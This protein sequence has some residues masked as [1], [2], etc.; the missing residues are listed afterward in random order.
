MEVSVTDYSKLLS[1]F[2]TAQGQ[3]L[4][5]RERLRIM[6]GLHNVELVIVDA[7]LIQLD[8]LTR[9]LS[10]LDDIQKANGKP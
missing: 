1:D 8:H 4:M 9:H 5:E 3:L 10:A 6:P 7:T 2:T